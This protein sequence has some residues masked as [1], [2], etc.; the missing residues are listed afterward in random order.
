MVRWILAN[1]LVRSRSEVTAVAS[2]EALADQEELQVHSRGGRFSRVI[3]WIVVAAL[4]IGAPAVVLGIHASGAS[5]NSS[6]SERIDDPGAAGG[7]RGKSRTL[8]H[9]EY[10]LFHRQP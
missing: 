7:A 2:G 10:I 6:S 5:Q 1:H 3:L 9:A 8:P 4:T